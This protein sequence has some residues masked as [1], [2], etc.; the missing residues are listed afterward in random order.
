MIGLEVAD[1][2][3][4]TCHAESLDEQVCGGRESPDEARVKLQSPEW[5]LRLV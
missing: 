5:T 1:G 4:P 3:V 2:A